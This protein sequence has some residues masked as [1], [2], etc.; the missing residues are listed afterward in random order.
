MT[1]T[2]TGAKH[3]YGRSWLRGAVWAVR[4][5]GVL[6]V[7][8]L[9]YQ[10]ITAGRVLAGDDGALSLHGVGAIAVHI[11]FGLLV[12]VTVAY[13]GP[14]RNTPLPA[15]VAVVL[16]GLSFVQA[17]LGDAGRWPPMYPSRW[18]SPSER[19]GSRPGRLRSERA[20]LM[21]DQRSGLALG[22][23]ARTRIAQVTSGTWPGRR[24][25]AASRMGSGLPRR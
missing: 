25:Q 18:H 1:D 21:R 13:W 24:S 19:S 3:A 23:V 12:A 9:L 7:L 15:V 6:S 22:A 11:V 10:F 16:F 20:I 4:V 5:T 8:V 17:A 14:R 2:D